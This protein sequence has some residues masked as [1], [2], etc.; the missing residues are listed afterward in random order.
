MKLQELGF[1]MRQRRREQGLTQAQVAK[2]AGVSRTTLSQLE[3][4]VLPDLGV[5]KV[6]AILDRL[7]LTL[8]VQPMEKPVRPDFVQMA[9]TTASVSFRVPLTQDELVNAL[10]TGKV[11]QGKRA[12]FRTLLD[13]ASPTL[14]NG[15]IEEVTRWSKPGRAEKNLAKIATDVAASRRIESWLKT[16]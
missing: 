15:L 14:L 13:E 7:G 4:G 11:P 9:S 16:A 3:N 5:R 2:A 6:Q 12:H 1:E 10:L 8:A